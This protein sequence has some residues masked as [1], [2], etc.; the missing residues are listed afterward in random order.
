[1]SKFELL[2][3]LQLDDKCRIYKII[4]IHAKIF[5]FLQCQIRVKLHFCVSYVLNCVT[6]LYAVVTTNYT[7]TIL[8]LL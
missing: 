4:S 8:R 1:M 2:F 3:A 7:L 5:Y 6:L